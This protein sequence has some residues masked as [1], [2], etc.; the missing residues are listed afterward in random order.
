M[1]YAFILM[2]FISW[3]CISDN[4]KPPIPVPEKAIKETKTPVQKVIWHWENRFNRDEVT[5]IKLWLETVNSAVTKTFGK[6]PFEIHYYIHRSKKGNEPVPWAHTS[7]GEKQSVHFHVNMDYFL[8]DFLTDWTAQH[9]ISHLSIPFVGREYSWFSEGYATF[10]QYQVMQSQG[11]YSAL[12][13]HKKYQSRVA[14]CKL[15]YQTNLTLPEAADSLRAVWNYPDMYW[16]GVSF[17]WKLD[18]DYQENINQS[19]TDVITKYVE[20]CRVN[21][22]TPEEF[23]VVLDS[24]SETKI[25]TNLLVQYETQPAYLIFEKM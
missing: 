11:V 20:C 23:C 10:M 25:A 4:P 19:L 2:L 22:S 16:G 1:K 17:F 3:G 13:I 15:S 9:E 8:E 14:K 7:R 6:Y 5:Q 12:E 21:E 18:K 24:I